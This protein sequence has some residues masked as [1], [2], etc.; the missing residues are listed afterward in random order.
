MFRTINTDIRY[1]GTDD[2]DITL[3]ENQYPVPQGISYNSYVIFDEKVAVMDTVDCRKGE[4]WKNNLREAL[5]GRTPDY[6]VVHHMEPDHS[7]LIAWFA[8]EFPDSTIVAS[9]KGV[10]M[11][12]Q[13]FEDADFSGRTLAVKEGDTLSLGRHELK[14]VMAPMVHWPEVMVSYDHTEGILFSA[15]AFGKFGN[16]ADCGFYDDEDND[17]ETEGA[18]YYFNICG[19]YGVQVQMLLKKAAALDIRTICPLH[20][21]VIRKDPARFVGLY[22]RWSLYSPTKEGVLIAHASIHGG[23]ADAARRFAKMVGEGARLVD[24][25]TTDPS[26]AVSLA[27]LYGKVVL[28]ASSYDAGLF[29]P[30]YEFL[31]HLQDK[32]WQKRSVGIIENGSWGPTAARVMKELLSQ[33][34]DI[35]LVGNVVT[36]RS[37]MKATDVPPMQELAHAINS[38]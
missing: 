15:D 10:P 20:G 6:L 9:A 25:T 11:L 12:S 21:P 34:K 27:F 19:K 17:W 23:T 24:L 1:I 31:H 28:A 18:R 16:L 2:I 32:N 4:E 13:F 30:M 36:I 7:S 5:E 38:I 3:F 35:S 33:M 29:P 26:E 22:D 8:A 14:F 37:R